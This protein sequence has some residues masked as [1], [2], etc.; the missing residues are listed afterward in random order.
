MAS[1]GLFVLFCFEN[2]IV[3]WFVEEDS[4]EKLMQGGQ[5]AGMMS[6]SWGS[7]SGWGTW[8]CNWNTCGSL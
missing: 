1:E 8:P 6:V 3:S 4:E 7:L 2:S 5:I